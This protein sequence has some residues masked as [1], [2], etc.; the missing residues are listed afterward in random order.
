LI[1][2]CPSLKTNYETESCK[3][4]HWISVLIPYILIRLYEYFIYIRERFKQKIIMFFE[5]ES[6]EKIYDLYK[7]D[8]LQVE[9]KN[10]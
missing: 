5:I 8:N 1:Y 2:I 7:I 3:D 9:A 4:Y 10:W 6:I